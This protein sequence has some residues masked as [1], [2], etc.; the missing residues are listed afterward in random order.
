M[1]EDV[2][3]SSFYDELE[4]IASNRARKAHTRSVLAK[5]EAEGQYKPGFR[6][7]DMYPQRH[8]EARGVKKTPGGGLRTL[9]QHAAAGG[10]W[11]TMS[12]TQGELPRENSIGRSMAKAR[13]SHAD[14][15]NAL[16]RNLMASRH[17]ARA[18]VM[19]NPKASDRYWRHF[20]KTEGMLDQTFS[21]RAA[22]LSKGSKSLPK[23]QPRSAPVPRPVPGATSAGRSLIGGPVGKLKA[24]ARTGIR[25]V[26]RAG[27]I[28]F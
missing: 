28:K 22:N 18:R 23:F 10:A 27:P 26:R 5:A 8:T 11:E 17:E 14:A 21:N 1:D 20:G 25:A 15:E 2:I 16:Q 6:Q 9:R 7:N 19:G 3:L 13:P 12:G 24:L 4:K